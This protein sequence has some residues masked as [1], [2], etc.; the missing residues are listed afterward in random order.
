MTHNISE[1]IT[2]IGVSGPLTATMI[3]CARCL[4]SPN[5]K[6]QS[7]LRA[8]LRDEIITWHKKVREREVVSA[9]LENILSSSLQN[10]EDPNPS[11]EINIDGNELINMVNKAVNAVM[12]RL[13]SNN[14]FINDFI[15]ELN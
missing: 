13:Q 2:S 7:I 3:S 5:F 6:V 8:I 11:G 9:S 15:N 1:F 4:V 12:G 10:Q 14:D